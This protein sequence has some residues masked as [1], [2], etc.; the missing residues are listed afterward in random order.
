MAAFDT[1]IVDHTSKSLEGWRI[2][3]R[4]PDNSRNQPS[5]RRISAANVHQL[6][7]KWV[8]TTGSD[9]SAT[10]TVAG[11]TVY[12]PDWAGN[13]YAVRAD[14][15]DLLWSRKI[16]DYNGRAGSI[17]RVSPAIFE[18]QLIIGD[19]TGVGWLAE[20]VPFIGHD[21]AHVIAMCATL[22]HRS[23]FASGRA[24]HGIA[25]VPWDH[26]LCRGLVGGGDARRESR[27]SVLHVSR[28]HGGAQHLH[29][30]DVVEDVH[31]A[32]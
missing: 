25:G 18:D 10:P 30:C 1:G 17:S 20:G 29:R 12:F 22:D 19:H 16:S 9:V 26:G 14:N 11:N 28:E 23:R 13:L 24:H 31:G 32:G 4:D 21:G 6:V 8:F 7:P 5:E 27:I 2:A 15:G 3:G